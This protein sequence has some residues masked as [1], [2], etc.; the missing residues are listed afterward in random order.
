[1]HPHA[2]HECQTC[3]WACASQPDHSRDCLLICAADAWLTERN[4]NIVV[5]LFC[6]QPQ[7]T[8]N[9]V[10]KDC[11]IGVSAGSCKIGVC[12]PA[13]NS[14]GTENKPENTNCTEG[15]NL[16]L[17]CTGV[18]NPSGVCNITC[19]RE[20]KSNSS[21]STAT[22]LLINRSMLYAPVSRL[23]WVQLAPCLQPCD[24]LRSPV[25]SV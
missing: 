23:L 6:L 2:M 7:G 16:A 12:V 9:I 17:G 3:G 24:P 4:N 25:P 10:D 8:C 18:C 19:P 21:K 15:V 11:S 13:S 22:S 20:C 1:M 14:C 5:S